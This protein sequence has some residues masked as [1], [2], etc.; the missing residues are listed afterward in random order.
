M[1]QGEK[2]DQWIPL[3]KVKHGKINIRF[4]WFDLSSDI[5]HLKTVRFAITVFDESDF[6]G[7]EI[8]NTKFN[9]SLEALKKYSTI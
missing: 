2:T 7:E 4:T 8:A 6:L 5:S 1:I 9:F 3:E